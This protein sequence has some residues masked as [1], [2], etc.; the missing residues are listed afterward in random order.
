MAYAGIDVAK[1]HLDL[2]LRRGGDVQTARFENTSGGIE[3]LVERLV[4]AEPERVALEATGGYERPAAA[5]LGAAGLPVAVANPRQTRDFAK[6]SGRLAKTDEI[7]AGVLALFA[8]R[9]RPEVRPLPDEAQQAFSALVTRRRQL[10]DM[11]T[12]ESNRL[13]TAPSEVVRQSIRAVL[14]ALA[15][16]IEEAERQLDE[17]VEESPMWKEQA[18]LLQSVPGVGKTTAYTLVAGLPELGEANRQEIAKLTRRNFCCVAPL[19][20]DSGTYRGTRGTWGGRKSVRAALSRGCD[21]G[22]SLQRP[23][24]RLLSWLGRAGQSQESRTGSDDAEAACNLEHDGQE[25]RAVAA[26]PPPRF[27]LTINT[28][29]RF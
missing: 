12:A 29:A 10:L 23:A 18:Q 21:G 6:A 4:E 13:G 7:D 24:G 27:R 9:M 22:D 20:R 28:V 15:E 14:A 1:E 25:R 5:A 26:R 11:R 16:Q 3:A 2:A 17:A 8:E 19:N